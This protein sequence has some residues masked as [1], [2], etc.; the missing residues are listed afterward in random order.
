MASVALPRAAAGSRQNP[1]AQSLAAAIAELAARF[2]ERCVT[3]EALRRQHAHNLTY[4]EAQL[5]DGVIFA[6]TA[7]DISETVKICAAHR[8]PIVPFGAGTSVEGHV[9]APFG[10][11]SL[12]L[13]Q[14]N[15]V[16]AVSPEDGTCVV[17]PGITRI[18]LNDHLRSYGLFFPVDPGA[19]ATIG[20]MVATRASGTAAVRY[21]TMRENVLALKAV[22]AD[23]SV[24]EAGRA[25][26]KS[27]SGYDLSH[28]FVGSEG[29]LGVISEVSL[30]VFPA[31]EAILAGY[32]HFETIE[33]AC[34]A[35][36]YALQLGIPLARVEL[37]DERQIE[38]ANAYSKLELDLAPHLFIEFNGT[39]DGVQLQRRQFE[40]AA[41]EFGGKGYSWATRTEERNALWTA[42]HNVYWANASYRPGTKPITTDLCV[43]ISRLS[44][45]IQRTKH[46]I[47]KSGLVGMIVAHV[48]DGN[49]HV[50]F[51]VDY[52]SDE[53]ERT[54]ALIADMTHDA[55][56]IGG[57]CTG[58]HGIGQGKIK[59]MLEEH[60]SAAIAVMHTLKRAL[61]PHN[62]FNPGKILLGEAP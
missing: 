1:S 53:R 32:C 33:S 59:Y 2:G 8:V 31:P 24:V 5:P 13:S 18:E 54:F 4:H 3:S 46:K 20:G 37:L 27:S 51:M 26:R 42:R 25:V 44:G 9:N 23:G 58:E 56:A 61:D 40:E 14:M 52:D 19:N 22:V 50:Q 16:L 43:P 45:I 49:F 11:I 12:D 48:G 15:G 47:I 17:E 30:R 57:T 29:T 39:A 38:A 7:E 10:G 41:S 60:G 35:A 21:G 6:R 55:L 62:I 34:D 36:V 28:L